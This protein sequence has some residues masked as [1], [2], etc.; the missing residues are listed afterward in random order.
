MQPDPVRS[1]SSIPPAGVRRDAVLIRA[2]KAAA[3]PNVPGSSPAVITS[4][5]MLY[6]LQEVAPKLYAH[7]AKE[8]AADLDRLRAPAQ[9]DAYVHGYNAALDKAAAAL[10]L[11]DRT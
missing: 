6:V 3:E 1:P 11:E 10:G 7:W 9:D 4:N 8:Q 2:L 5:R